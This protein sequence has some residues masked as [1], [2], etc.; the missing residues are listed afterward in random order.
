MRDEYDN[1]EYSRRR[2]ETNDGYDDGFVIV[3]LSYLNFRRG[4]RREETLSSV[5]HARNLIMFVARTSIPSRGVPPAGDDLSYYLS[6]Y[7]ANAR[8]IRFDSYGRA[9]NTA[10]ALQYGSFREH[11]AQH[12]PIR[13]AFLH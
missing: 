12:R 10:L 9:T 6:Y 3:P 11:P 5:G 1:Y 13:L 4:K 7:P 8:A 2:E